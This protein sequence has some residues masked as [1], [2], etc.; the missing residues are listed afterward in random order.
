M[1]QLEGRKIKEV[2]FQSATSF[3]VGSGAH[4]SLVSGGEPGAKITSL[5]MHWTPHGLVWK[6]QAL[7]GTMEGLVP[8][9]QCQCIIFYPE[10][11]A[12]VSKKGK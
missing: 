5:E 11:E 3:G 6:R 1:K 8:L 9:P 2:Q 10:E 7:K 4:T 12:A